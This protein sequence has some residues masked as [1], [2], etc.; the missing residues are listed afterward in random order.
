MRALINLIAQ[1]RLLL[2]AAHF[3]AVML[4]APT[5]A[6]TTAVTIWEI[7]TGNVSMSTPLNPALGALVSYGYSIPTLLI[8][9]VLLLLLNRYAGNTMAKVVILFGYTI[10]FGWACFKFSDRMENNELLA[11][12]GTGSGAMVSCMLFTVWT[13]AHKRIGVNNVC[14]TILNIPQSLYFTMLLAA[15]IATSYTLLLY[16]GY[17]HRS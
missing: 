16:G 7:A 2:I 13:K 3:L 15:S 1:N 8:A 9:I 11:I 14:G 10:L 6:L 4:I 17:I 12:T 5:T